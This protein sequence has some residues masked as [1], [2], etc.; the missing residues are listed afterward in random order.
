M[1]LVNCCIVSSAK[2]IYLWKISQAIG[3]GIT[4]KS[5]YVNTIE[6]CLEKE[7]KGALI[8]AYLGK[9]K[10]SL[11]LID[12]DIDIKDSVNAFGS[13]IKF[14]IGDRTVPVP[15]T[16]TTTSTVPVPSVFDVLM[17]AQRITSLPKRIEK[18]K[19]SKKENL[20]NAVL[21]FPTKEK[22]GWIQLDVDGVGIR[23]VSAL[24]DTLWY[25]D[26]LNR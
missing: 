2:M 26:V 4:I 18:E 6:P 10:D 9:S 19:M 21:E 15:S 3:E 1:T 12:L 25:I 22:V 17:S 13:F 7:L 23:F 11:D 20:Y 16:T 5:F 8:K 14:I 24:V